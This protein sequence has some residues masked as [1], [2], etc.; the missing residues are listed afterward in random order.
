MDHT[1]HSKLKLKWWLIS[2]LCCKILL[3]IYLL[4]YETGNNIIAEESGY[5]KDV[6]DEGYGTLVQK[7][8]YSYETP[9]GQ[10]KIAYFL[11]VMNH[12]KIKIP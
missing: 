9:E 3:I 10:V 5:L 1:R 6:N 4:S 2:S 11:S 8:S 12:V 7:G